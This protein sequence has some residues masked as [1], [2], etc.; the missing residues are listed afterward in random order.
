MTNDTPNTQITARSTTEGSRRMPMLKRFRPS[1]AMIVAC[2]ALLAALAGTGVAAV[3]VLAP[4]NS[5]GS[6]QVINQSLKR[7]D[8]A[9]GQLPRGLRGLR[10]LAGP[11]GAA[12]PAGPAGAAGAAGAQGPA[13]ASD[14]YSRFL[15]GP[16][17]IPAS[18]TTLATLAIPQAGN[19][20]VFG[21]AYFDS[22]AGVTTTCRLNAAGDTDQSQAWA[23]STFPESVALN[24]VHN[25]A[26]AGTVEFQCQAA[27]AQNANFI[28]ITAIRLG[29]LSNSG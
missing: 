20:V 7:A 14:A 18:L 21:K 28:K 24:V 6:L 22:G 16:I 15:N 2:V 23:S 8:F 3:K 1:P 11:A 4:A 25:F 13:G 12:G 5:V 10:G 17:A 26:A 19:Y 9:P 27:T 29:N